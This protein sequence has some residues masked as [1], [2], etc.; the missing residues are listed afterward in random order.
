MDIS[1]KIP[2]NKEWRVLDDRII[3]G[4]KEVMLE[5]VK[6]VKLLAKPTFLTNGLYHVEYGESNALLTLAYDKNTADKASEAMKYVEE[7]CMGIELDAKTERIMK[8]LEE[9]PNKDMFGTKKEIK[10]LPE[11]IGDDEHLKAITSG[12]VD[13]N[14]WLMVCTNKRVLLIDKGMIYGVKTIDI[15]LDMINSISHSKGL[16]MGKI[17]ITDGAKSRTIENISNLTITF[18]T[19]TVKEQ[20]AEYKK[21]TLQPTQQA[22]TVS[23]A[24]ELLKFK[25]LLDLGAITQEEYDSK[26]SELLNK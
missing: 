15:P 5:D 8:E 24:D 7:N 1:V 13:G 20:M 14:T 2:F 25:Q 16:M 12:F 26:K 10:S 23:V 9:L 3:Y 6:Q 19:E 11:L 18:F 21:S 4:K 22:N 17:C